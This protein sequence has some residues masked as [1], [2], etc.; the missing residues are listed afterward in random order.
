MNVFRHCNW[1]SVMNFSFFLLMQHEDPEV[2][3]VLLKST[4]HKQSV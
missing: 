2:G 3:S 1:S 4:L